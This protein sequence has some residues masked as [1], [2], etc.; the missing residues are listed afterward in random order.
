MSMFGVTQR[1]LKTAGAKFQ[2]KYLTV[3]CPVC[4]AVE[5]AMCRSPKFGTV[6]GNTH[7]ERT[8]V[9]SKEVGNNRIVKH[10]KEERLF[11]QAPA[12]AN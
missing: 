4:F 12:E 9:L 1:N 7:L 3:E 10:L 11:T 2:D 5:G 6:L 8:K